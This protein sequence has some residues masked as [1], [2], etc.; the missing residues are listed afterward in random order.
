MGSIVAKKAAEEDP[1][2]LIAIF[3]SDYGISL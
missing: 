1:Q 3:G 2:P